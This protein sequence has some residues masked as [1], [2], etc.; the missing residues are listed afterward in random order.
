MRLFLWLLLVLF[1]GPA[2]VSQAAAS[3]DLYGSWKT[4]RGPMIV[5]MLDGNLSALISSPRGIES[6]RGTP[7]S[8]GFALT[9]MGADGEQL[10]G[11]ISAAAD[12]SSLRGTIGTS[13][14]ARRLAS[15]GAGPAVSD[16]AL[17][18][19]AMRQLTFAKAILTDV[20]THIDLSFQ[21]PATVV[22]EVGGDPETLRQWVAANTLLLPYQGALRTPSQVL[23]DRRGGSLDRARLL[24]DL[25]GRAGVKAR[26]V[27]GDLAP[28]ARKRIY[29]IS[30]A[31]IPREPGLIHDY[32]ATAVAERVA[33]I[34]PDQL[35][36]EAAALAAEDD[37]SPTDTFRILDSLM[38]L[39]HPDAPSVPPLP[40]EYWWVEYEQAGAWTALPLDPV[41]LPQGTENYAA[42]ALPDED[43]H[44]LT[45]RVIVEADAAGDGKTAESTVLVASIRAEDAAAG[46]LTLSFL[47][48]GT[49]IPDSLPDVVS[50]A[51]ELQASLAA[52]PAWLPVLGLGDETSPGLLFVIDGRVMSPE[53]ASAARL[54]DGL[55]PPNAA[56]ATSDSTNAATSVLNNLFSDAP[57]PAAPQPIEDRLMG[58][59]LEYLVEVPGEPDRLERRTVWDRFG[60]GSRRA[61][62]AVVPLSPGELAARAAALTDTRHIVVRTIVERDESLLKRY[63]DTLSGGFDEF[64]VALR[65]L[66]DGTTRDDLPATNAVSTAPIIYEWERRSASIGSLL[67][68]MQRPDIVSYVEH[69]ALDGETDLPVPDLQLDIV[70]SGLVP[71]WVG[72]DPFLLR[73]QQGIAATAA[74]ANVVDRGLPVLNTA[75]AYL[76][77][78]DEGT[79]WTVYRTVQELEQV[80]LP[81]PVAR[82][83][84]ADLA[85]GNVVVAPAMP[86]TLGGTPWTGYWRIDPLTGETLGMGPTGGAALTDY[87]L[88]IHSTLG[89][90]KLWVARGNNLKRILNAL[91]CYAAFHFSNGN[92]A[93]WTGLTFCLVGEALS[94]PGALRNWKKAKALGNLSSQEKKFYQLFGEQ[95]FR[96]GGEQD[97]KR[98]IMA[99]AYYSGD[100]ATKIDDVY[101]LVALIGDGIKYSGT[102]LGWVNKGLSA[103]S[104]SK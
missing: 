40:S 11:S 25:L 13:F 5:G 18:A 58:I 65:S 51:A 86:I 62:S 1:T 88:R 36:K 28:D 16:P 7:A 61:A 17:L 8:D 9:V 98:K 63:A 31:A 22:D 37:D 94:G 85:R 3:C 78:L 43:F 57:E 27:R 104:R 100:T 68:A 103:H 73:M 47:P 101:G 45:V 60:T 41:E 21:D 76:R 82:L 71:Y 102:I 75:R 77:S 54:V 79:D 35:T 52:E 12:C 72:A 97:L 53:D 38:G 96:N 89:D 6:V 23:A 10:E 2:A 66:V 64:L 95:L 90:L 46:D 83:A 42:D 74:E 48:G 24:V 91:A 34:D 80:G 26:L 32:D 67:M 44:R 14:V 56:D 50:N 93:A 30:S 20:S 99:A 4:T 49:A 70:E 19:D 87:L 59:Y 81:T 55:V 69:S 84:M 29:D 15:V 92:A 39:V 33:G